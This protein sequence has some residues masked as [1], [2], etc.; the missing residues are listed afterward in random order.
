MHTTTSSAR[1]LLARRQLPLRRPDLPARQPAA[2]RAAR[3]RAHQAAAAR[4]LGHDAGPQLH[5]RAPEPGHPAARPR[6]DLSSPA[7]AMAGRRWSPTPGSKAPTASSIPNVS[8]DAEGMRAAVPASSPF[9]AA[10]RSHVAPETPGSIH[11]GGELGYALSHAFGAAFDNPD[12]IVACVVGDGEA[13]TGPLAAVLA[14]QQVPQPGRA[15]ARC[16]RS[17]TST[18]TRSPIRRCSRASR[19]AELRSACWS[20]TATSRISSRA[21]DPGRCTGGWRQTLDTVIDEI[22]AIQHAARRDG[23]RRT[24]A[25]ADDR[26]AHAQGLDRAEGGRRQEEPKASGAR[27]RCRW[28]TW[29]TTRST[30]RLLE[31]WM[32]SYRPEELFDE[33][34]AP[35]A[36]IAALA[37]QGARRM[38]ANPHANGGLAAE[39]SALA[40]LPRQRRR[41]AAARRGD[42]RSDARHGR[43]PARR[44]EAQPRRPQLP[45]RRPGRDRLEP[46]RTRCSR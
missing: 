19:S 4:P 35:R 44:D 41:R 29:P 12:L 7:R 31:Q 36:E 46:A 11:E 6:H 13:E 23:V 18:A 32:Q 16:C 10:F 5:L 21:T 40:R 14:F 43:L 38:G 45:R 15:T 28:P 25:L 42:R 9:P 20:A 26:A 8:R 34:G 2:A 1:R 24:P 33:H 37:P 30:L 39:G 22:R 3:A 27:T 17:C